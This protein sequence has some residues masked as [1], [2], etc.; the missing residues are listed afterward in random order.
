MVEESAL[1]NIRTDVTDLQKKTAMNEVLISRFDTALDKISEVSLNVSKLLAVHEQR[2][3]ATESQSKELPKLIESHRQES[4]KR[5]EMAHDR[6]N[7]VEAA[8]RREATEM[9]KEVLSEIKAMRGDMS[10]LGDE[11]K[12]QA[13]TVQ[14]ELTEEFDK[15]IEVVTTRVTTLERIQWIAIGG[16]TVIG[17]LLSQALGVFELLK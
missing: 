13:E 3:E 10:D 14:D 1:Q 9:H 7:T 17:F 15:K 2:L 8:A 4:V 16:A 12:E 11:L 6:I 5:F